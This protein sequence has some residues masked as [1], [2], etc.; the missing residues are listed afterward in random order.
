MTRSVVSVAPVA[1]A[2]LGL[3]SYVQ[4]TSPIRR[5]TDMLAHFQMKA[6]LR[7]EAPPFSADGLQ[8]LADGIAEAGRALGAAEREVGK[9]WFA[10]W[11]ARLPR[12][13]TLEGLV[14]GHMRPDAPGLAHVLLAE[15]GYE[16]VTRVSPATSPG[17]TVFLAV[18]EADAPTGTVRFSVVGVRP[19]NPPAEDEDGDEGEEVEEEEGEEEGEGEEIAAA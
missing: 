15:C 17:D 4:F 8:A 1:H 16:V 6:H 13:A 11:A 10:L 9:Y 19:L 2:S 7:G 5:Y 18:D 3:D 12:D 14:L